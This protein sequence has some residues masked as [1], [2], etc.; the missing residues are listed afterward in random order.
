MTSSCKCAIGISQTSQ[1]SSVSL[2]CN[3]NNCY[4]SNDNANTSVVI[5]NVEN[6]GNNA[7][8]VSMGM[9][10]EENTESNITNNNI[11]VINNES[12]DNDHVNFSECVVCSDGTPSDPSAP[13]DSEMS[14]A[15]DP[16]KRPIEEV[17]VSDDVI[18]DFSSDSDS[19]GL[20]H[21]SK[22]KPS[23]KKTAVATASIPKPRAS[24][25]VYSDP[26]GLASA[27][28]LSS[29]SKKIAKKTLGHIPAGVVSAVRA[30][31]P[32]I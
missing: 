18:K 10:N 1:I 11:G 32:T 15:S 30:C 16:L 31:R 6:T 8:N 4:G 19:V 2:L 3:G 29:A 24:K 26:V 12:T 17:S 9:V 27:S 20:A 23:S 5:A 28:K 14:E 22:S 25:S 21:P 13:V 7:I